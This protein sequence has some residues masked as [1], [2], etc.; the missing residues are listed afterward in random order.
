MLLC[1][2]LALRCLP[3]LPAFAFIRH[4]SR[5]ALGIRVAPKASNRF[6]CA[7][8]FLAILSIFSFKIRSSRLSAP[9]SAEIFAGESALDSL[10]EK[11]LST[12]DAPDS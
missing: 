10:L 1:L 4:F 12:G 7:G 11:D 5:L 8:S 2:A 6:E 9:D 3:A